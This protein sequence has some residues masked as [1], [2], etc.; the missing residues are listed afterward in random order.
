MKILW[1][2]NVKQTD[3]AANSSGTWLHPLATGLSR[4]GSV[5]LYN[6]SIDLVSKTTRSDAG[7]IAQWLLPREELMVNRLPN[8][9]LIADIQGIVNE[10]DPDI[11]HVWG[12]ELPWGLLTARGYLRGNILLEI[13]GLK[14]TVAD[15]FYSGL[16]T[17][18]LLST[19]NIN[20]FIKPSASLPG[21]KRSFR[22]WGFNEKEMILGHKMISTQSEWVRANVKAINPDARLFKTSMMLRSEFRETPRWC[23]EECI[24]FRIFSIT[25]SFVSYKGF[26]V[27]LRAAA[28]LRRQYPMLK[29]VLAGS[30]SY[31]LRADGYTKF[32]RK[33]VIELGLQESVDWI[34]P[35]KANEIVDQFK[36]A[37]VVIIPSFVE[38]YCLSLDEA[39]TVGVPVVASY[40]GAMP[41]L[42]SNDSS[43]LFFPPGDSVLCAEK[44][45]RVFSE[46][47]LAEYLSVTAYKER[48]KATPDS[49]IKNQIM[50]YSECLNDRLHNRNL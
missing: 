25:S 33:L 38:S 39:L 27:L 21:L 12:T 4:T 48:R 28:I 2:S 10:I 24:P 35:L 15:H 3:A 42:A 17:L 18:E 6:I 1:L 13:Q 41:E 23:K 34:G 36:M 22:K 50:I 8:E 47:D 20:E 40:A 31:R 14:F 5:E 46:K 45:S 44:V 29:V 37:N 32:L 19:L 30:I 16:T 49:I 9:S 43:A 11:I 7:K 26:H